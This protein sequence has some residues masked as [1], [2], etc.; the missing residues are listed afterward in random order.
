MPPLTCLYVSR[1]PIYKCRSNM[2][3][4]ILKLPTYLPILV[5]GQLSAD[6]SAVFRPARWSIGL[7]ASVDLAARLERKV[8][9]R[10]L[11]RSMYLTAG[12]LYGVFVL[13]ACNSPYIH[14]LDDLAHSTGFDSRYS[15]NLVR[16]KI[17]NYNPG[18]LASPPAYRFPTLLPVYLF[19][20]SCL[21][22]P[23]SQC[24]IPFD[25]TG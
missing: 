25:F 6:P 22:G 21:P 4:P 1:L 12:S 20:G 5:S 8:V 24:S 17:K 11:P 15:N 18:K 13:L 9:V 10:L 3:M 14:H 2:T 23:C 16:K 19:P 7:I